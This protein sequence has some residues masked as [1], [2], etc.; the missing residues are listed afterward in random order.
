M[1]LQSLYP[2]YPCLLLSIHSHTPVH[3]LFS[4][5]FSI[6]QLTAAHILS[7]V[8]RPIAINFYF[9]ILQV[10]LFFSLNPIQHQF[11][12]LPII[13]HLVLLLLSEIIRLLFTIS[14]GDRREVKIYLIFFEGPPVIPGKQGNIESKSQSGREHV[15][16]HGNS[17]RPVLKPICN[18]IF[19]ALLRFHPHNLLYSRYNIT[20]Y[21]V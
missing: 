19:I 11:L 1:N 13:Q 3:I 6:A 20:F 5:P 9:L 7:T 15:Y 21:T 14:A 18:D 16:A 8:T 17:N 12:F 2:F 10:P 4:F